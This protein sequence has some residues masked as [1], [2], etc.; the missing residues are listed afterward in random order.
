M[1]DRTLLAKLSRCGWKV[2][3][4]YLKQAVPKDG[5][6][7]GATITVHTFGD[8]Q[9]FHCHLHVLATDGCFYGDGSFMAVP[10]PDARDLEEAFRYEI[11]KMLK[12]EGKINDAIIENMMSWHHSGF[13]IYCGNAIWPHDEKGLEDLARYLIRASFS[14]ERMIYINSDLSSKA[15]RKNWARMIQKIYEIDPLVCPKCLG[16]MKIISI[17]EDQPVIRKIL[18]HLELW[19]I[20]IHDP[21]VPQS[22]ELS[23]LAYDDSFSQL[24]PEEYWIQ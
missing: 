13:N 9:E 15:F 6:K 10:K 1:Y 8:F 24:P 23:E 22:I 2:L 18:K 7:P 16:P 19:D 12:T 4:S 3:N 5:A 21:P 11:L 14:Q 17:I 20:K